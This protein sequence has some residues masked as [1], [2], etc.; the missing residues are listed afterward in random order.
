MTDPDDSFAAELR[1]L[2]PSAPR[3]EFVARLD[4]EL[5]AVASRRRRARAWLW[6]VA[7]PA[8]AALAIFIGTMM[9]RDFSRAN[10]PASAGAARAMF[11]PVAA[12]NVLYAARDEGFVTLD[13][14]TTARRE[15]LRYI[16]TITWKN[17]RTHA[18]LQWSVPR[19]EIRVVPVS[20]Q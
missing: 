8:A 14:G 6:P 19:E 1:Q 5:S 3:S 20:F 10:I 17:P 12:E 11:K 15:R 7:L 9:Q 4:R 2:R 18:S 16:D 13:D